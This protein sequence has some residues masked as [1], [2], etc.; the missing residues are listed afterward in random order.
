MKK[1]ILS[2]SVI[3]AIFANSV[4]AY[5]GTIYIPSA[6]SSQYLPTVKVIAYAL[7]YDGSLIAEG[8]GSGTL[9]DS[10]GTIATN[11]HVV[12][13]AYDPTLPADAFQ[14]CLTRSNAP[15]S[16]ICEFVASLV[17]M[18]EVSDIALLRMDSIDARGNT[19]NFDFNLPYQNNGNPAIGDALTVIGYPN[20][21]GKTIT[22]TTGIVSGFL[23]EQGVL[24]GMAIGGTKYIKTDAVISSGNSGGTAVDK[25]GNFIGI[26]SLGLATE[27]LGELLPVKDFAPWISSKIGLSVASDDPAKAKL[28]AAEKAS[29]EA[30]ITGTFKNTDPSYEISV[31]DGWKFSNSLDEVFNT[32]NAVIGASY[33]TNSILIVPKDDSVVSIGRI[34]IFLTDFSYTMGMDDLDYLLSTYAETDPSIQL[35]K[36]KLNG[37]YDAFKETMLSYDWDTGAALTI[38]THYIP[39]GNKVVS[40][41]YVYENEAF[42]PDLEAMVKT[43]KIDLSKAKSSQVD[44][45]TNKSPKITL[46]NPS[47]DLFLSDTS[48]DFDGTRYFSASFGQKRDFDFLVSMYSGE[49]WDDKYTGNFDLFKTDTLA[50]AAI[51]YSVVAQGSMYVDG[52]KGFY[53]ML[54]GDDGWG[55]VYKNT[56]AYVEI[57]ST[58]Y[59]S[60]YYSDGSDTYDANVG[61]ISKIL[62]SVSF[63]QGGKG[64]YFVPVIGGVASKI[65]VLSDIKNY[66]YEANI[67]TLNQLKVFGEKS[68]AKFEPGKKVS[69]E[70]FVVWAVKSLVGD[71]KADFE[72]FKISYEMCHDDCFADID[73]SSSNAMYISYAKKM[74]AVSGE[75]R[76]GKKY[77]DAGGNV[78]LAAA[79]KVLSK[80]NGVDVWEAPDYIA[81]Y[82][83]YLYVG[84]K[85]GIVPS[86]VSDAFYLVTRGEAA[87]MM[88][89]LAV[90]LISVS[91]F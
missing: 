81:W 91:W 90:S 14:V 8:Y 11:A 25:D 27:S 2:V 24:E 13:S 50:D 35:E 63:E 21:G 4:F 79:L 9:I 38:V 71:Q 15:D 28:F 17:S 23:E 78:T 61:Y 41:R 40:A 76:D 75:T 70:S 22:Y 43:F 60:L 42:V 54:E 58:Q 16:P 19:V 18:H 12:R 82:V 68:P 30:N 48:Y 77:F 6:S 73:Y 26:P 80:L 7:S 49:Y 59:L 55:G 33:G 62:K 67:K 89:T 74:G 34:E 52:H 72:K 10:K 83:P 53:Y 88:D 47:T 36:V 66:L 85:Y 3:F 5:A 51:W 20:I 64:K 44:T 87:F 86:G 37:K 45:V 65:S 56:I 29:V 69:R 46:K 84:Y 31:V 39:Y 32:S 1:F 57:D